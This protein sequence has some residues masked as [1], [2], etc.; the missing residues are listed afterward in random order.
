MARLRRTSPAVDIPSIHNTPEVIAAKAE[1]VREAVLR[2]SRHIE[3]PNFEK[4]GTDDLDRLLRLYD[5]HFFG[6]WLSETVRAKTPLPLVFRLSGRMTR[7]G[8]KATKHE[9]RQPDG[10]V[11]SYFEIA[12]AS[13]MLFMTFG[14][15]QRPVVVCGLTCE[16]RL[17]TLQRI[18]EHEIIHLAELLVWD[19]SS[20][21]GARFKAL[22]KNI[23]GH[24]GTR[25]ALVTAREHAAAQHQ[26][27]VG[28]TV[29]FQFEG[30][31]LVGRVNR[32]HRRAT[33][34][35]EDDEGQRYSDGGRY[36]KFY[37]PLDAIEPLAPQDNDCS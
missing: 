30:R 29:K 20:C 23:F 2:E 7:T 17:Q 21:S 9:Q 5:E 31:W 8:G 6:G 11:R 34:L 24:S 14:D 15:V 26:I 27:S 10:C 3:Q 33:V 25:H 28:S 19:R 35:V 36:T 4:I 12:I 37:V 1:A 32:I 18:M 22:A 16:D 13:Q